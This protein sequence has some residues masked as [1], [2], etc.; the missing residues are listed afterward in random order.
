[1]ISI[2]LTP[3]EELE[4]NQWWI[5]DLLILLLVFGLSY[6]G[7]YYYS[8]MNKDEL[9]VKEVEKQRITAEK[10]V[11]EADVKKF[12]SLNRKI[13]DLSSK[14]T[15]LLRITESKLTRFLPIILLENIQNLKPDGIWLESLAFVD[16]LEKGQ[17]NPPTNPQAQNKP[18]N[19]AQDAKSLGEGPKKMVGVDGEPKP[20]T[21]PGR[22]EGQ[23]RNSMSQ[24]QSVGG[25]IAIEIV[26]KGK[27]NI[28]I[29]E[30]MMS[31]KA[32][33]T[34][35][36]EKSDLRTQL[37]FNEIARRVSEALKAMAK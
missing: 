1:M 2:N 19:P 7:V 3:A 23:N 28:A 32:T 24:S 27:S 31:L 11:L 29:A 37:F 18:K 16:K 20:K 8:A 30:F 21:G 13:E 34:Q 35:R 17:T 9:I 10:I 26:G 15:A 4:D 36:F 6:G 14:K 25:P 5:P 33:Q 12:D 22:E